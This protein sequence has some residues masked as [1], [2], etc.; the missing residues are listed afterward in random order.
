MEL[1]T[2][3]GGGI[4]SLPLLHSI[5]LAPKKHIQFQFPLRH[6]KTISPFLLNQ[7]R[8]NSSGLRRYVNS[9]LR[10]A[11]SED[12]S[13]TE[14][15]PYFKDER[16]EPE[17]EPDSVVIVEDRQSGETKD[18][19]DTQLNEAPE[20]GSLGDNSPELFK[21]LEDF[22]I[23]FDYEDTYSILVLGGGSAVA[24]WLAAAVVGAIDSIPVVPKVLELI[25]LGYTVW[26][27]SRY[28]IFKENRD[29]L[30][31]RVEQ[32]KQQVLGARED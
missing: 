13:S 15:T 16:P 27:T 24:L 17:S 10:S 1:C 23:K 21:F 25:G 19:D 28:L 18:D 20:E 3:A 26:F 22:D 9:S 6:C 4:S 12:T 14:T 7:T 29:E 8:F 2:A 30:V 32:I 31:A 5:H 11:T